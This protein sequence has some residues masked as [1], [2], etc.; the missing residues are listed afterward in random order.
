MLRGL[1][2]AGGFVVAAL[3]LPALAYAAS[4]RTPIIPLSGFHEASS[5]LIVPGK[6]T[7]RLKIEGTT[8]SYDLTYEGLASGVTQAHIHIGEDALSGGVAAF[9]CTNLGNGP[10]GTLACP[11]P[12][13]RV[14]GSIDAVDVIGPAA[15]GPALV[16][17]PWFMAS[18]SLPVAASC[19]LLMASSP[20]GPGERC[21]DVGRARPDEVPEQAADF[22]DGQRQERG[23]QVRRGFL[24][25][26]R[27][28]A[29]RRD[30]RG[31]AWPG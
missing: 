10:A 13:D 20:A 29:A 19:A 25:R 23:G 6:G 14:T 26:P 4:N 3:V 30:R 31:P 28:C 2:A 8:I 9:L 22:R 17:Q 24:P 7:A 27:S 21:V 5:T 1:T 11:S 12:V 15:Q 18:T 16:L